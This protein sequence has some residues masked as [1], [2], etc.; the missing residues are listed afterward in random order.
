MLV[1]PK[2]NQ[3]QQDFADQFTADGSDFIY[4]KNQ[5]GAAIRVSQAERDAF[6]A[7]FDRRMRYFGWS[8]LP[9]ALAVTMVCFSAIFFWR[10]LITAYAG[11]AAYLVTAWAIHKWLWN[12]PARELQHRAPVKPP[13]TREEANELTYSKMTF[14]GIMG[15]GLIAVLIV[16]KLSLKM[17]VLHGWGRLQLLVG[18]VIVAVTAFAAFQKWR[19]D[20]D[21][22]D[23]QRT[24]ERAQRV[25]NDPGT[26]VRKG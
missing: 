2:S 12:A 24:S 15:G 6:V 3:A 18:A 9:S 8:I 13:L 21:R 11:F 1:S 4:R 25:E 20:Q 14:G 23:K 5:T 22:S 17:D 19:V 7:T 26:S 16:V 10:S